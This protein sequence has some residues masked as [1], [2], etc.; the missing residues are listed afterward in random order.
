MMGYMEY[1]M[2]TIEIVV[3]VGQVFVHTRY[4]PKLGGGWNEIKRL[5]KVIRV[6]RGAV[7]F[8]D[9]ETSECIFQR[10]ISVIEGLGKGHSEK[11]KILK[12][13]CLIRI[14]RT[15]HQKLTPYS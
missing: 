6:T 15:F 8:L 2:N 14:G 1:K 10:A 12:K 4:T 7:N 9:L 5:V 11:Y 3:R 13:A